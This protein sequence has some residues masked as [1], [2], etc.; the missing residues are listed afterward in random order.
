MWWGSASLRSHRFVFLLHNF[1]SYQQILHYHMEQNEYS[2]VIDTCKKYGWGSIA[3]PYYISTDNLQRIFLWISI[4][5]LAVR[6]PPKS[7]QYHCT[8]LAKS[9]RTLNAF[10]NIWS[11]CSPPPPHPQGVGVLGKLSNDFPLQTNASPVG[12]LSSV[13]KTFGQDCS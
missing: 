12:V 4:V 3:Q 10:A 7:W 9:L 11:F 6:A 8:I 13:P 1:N 5:N 2:H